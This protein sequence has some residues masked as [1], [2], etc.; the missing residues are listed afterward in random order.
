M[1]T[2]EINIIQH[3]QPGMVESLPYNYEFYNPVKICS[4]KKAME[5]IPF[6]LAAINAVRPLVLA[7]HSL[8]GR[9]A[10]KLLTNAFKESEM[11]FYVCDDVPDNADAETVR[12]LTALYLEKNHDAIIVAGDGAAVDIAKVIRLMVAEKTDDLEQLEGEIK[13]SH[14]PAPLIT[15]QTFDGSGLE[16]SGWAT[17]CNQT[18]F[19]AQL[20]PQICIID[21]RMIIPMDIKTTWARTMVSLTQ[22]VEVYMAADRNP[23]AI[24]YA[25]T[26]IQSIRKNL[27]PVFS[28]WVSNKKR[29]ALINAYTAAA[30]AFSNNQPG[31]GFLLGKAMAQMG[32]L[33]LGTAMGIILP[34][35]MT[36]YMR[37][38]NC[39]LADL[40]RPLSSDDDY[41]G[42]T[43]SLRGKKAIRCLYDLQWTWHQAGRR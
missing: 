18:F 19:S 33:N 41:A 24:N 42:T 25:S 26:A 40:L 14:A 11:S 2:K 32:N 16:A 5:H 21:P 23:V 12:R 4:G 30:C 35:V 38:T 17:V 36:Q 37:K 9:R 10:I 13:L 3:R 7:S 43:S 8:I 27:A 39:D 15:L 1:D 34:Y 29:L 28:K 31:P 22:A 6:E 20:A